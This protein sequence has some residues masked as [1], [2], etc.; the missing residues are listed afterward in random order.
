[1]IEIGKEY[2]FFYRCDDGDTELLVSYN[3]RKCR[4]IND[5]LN[6]DNRYIAC[7]G[8]YGVVF[9]DELEYESEFN[10]YGDE[11]TPIEECECSK[12]GIYWKK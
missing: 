12:Y 5:E 9:E 7:G 4:V 8:M 10:V 6:K 11:L 2:I 1:M 3:A